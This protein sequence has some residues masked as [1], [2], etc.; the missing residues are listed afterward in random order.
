MQYAVVCKDIDQIAFLYKIVWGICEK[1]FAMNV[2]WMS[3]IPEDIIQ[4]AAMI[5]QAAN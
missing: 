3:G 1:S 5:G 4:R 2:A